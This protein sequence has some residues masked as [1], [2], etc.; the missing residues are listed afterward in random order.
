MTEI[1]SSKHQVDTPVIAPILSLKAKHYYKYFTIIFNELASG[2]H[3]N[4]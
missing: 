3:K 4:F 1:Q 2:Q